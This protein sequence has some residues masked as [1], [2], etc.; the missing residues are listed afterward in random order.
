MHEKQYRGT[1]FAVFDIFPRLFALHSLVQHSGEFA[2]GLEIL[3]LLLEEDESRESS[4]FVVCCTLAC[5][6]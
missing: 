1:F 5:F 3:I 4:P 2:F 6:P